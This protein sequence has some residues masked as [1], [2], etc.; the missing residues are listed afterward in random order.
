MEQDPGQECVAEA[1]S[2]SDQMSRIAAAGR[3]TGLDLHADNLTAAELTE[4]VDLKPALL[5][6]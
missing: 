2:E 1:V 3:R 6:A 4:D 5:L